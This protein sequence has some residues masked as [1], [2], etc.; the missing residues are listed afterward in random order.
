MECVIVLRD[1]VNCY[2]QGL[3]PSDNEILKNQFSILTPTRFYQA[4]F[5]LG[6]WDGKISFFYEDGRT[7][8]N[9]L[10]KLVPIIESMGYTI[11]LLDKRKS[12]AYLPEPIDKFYLNDIEMNGTP[13]VLRDEQV[14]V[15]NALLASGGG[16]GKAATGAGKCVHPD[17]PI[18]MFDGTI[19]PIKDVLVGD[20][21]LGDDNTP[22]TVLEK[23]AGQSP[24]HKICLLY[25][26]PSPRD[27][28]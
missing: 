24:M 2:V 17:T 8:V 21:L 9:L 3:K 28:G 22:R 13:I 1:E 14:E 27:R 6:Q 18:I 12:T 10:E 16:I 4:A 11:K 5:K 25:T 15:I 26:S 23:T 20:I 19:K 7:Y